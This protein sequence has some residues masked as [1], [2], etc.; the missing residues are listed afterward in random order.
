[1]APSS[2]AWATGSSPHFPSH[3][4]RRRPPWPLRRRSSPADWAPLEFRVRMAI[5]T[6]EVERRGGDLFGPPMNRGSRLLNAGP[7]RPDRSF[8]RRSEAITRD[9]GAQ[10]KSLGEH[11]F[12]GLG[13]PQAV[14]QLL[15]GRASEQLSTAEQRR[16]YRS[17]S[18][19]ASATPFVDTNFGSGS[20]G[21]HLQPSTG[22]INPRSAERWRSRS[23][24]PSSPTIRH[25]SAGSNPRHGLWHLSSIPIS[26]RFTTTGGTPTAPT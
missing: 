25:S 24:S 20:G 11:R 21:V 15:V 10:V 4:W 22:A 6:G 19:A 26:S 1:M 2:R 18:I 13:T 5:D 7:R 14:H 12:K 8:G 9:A 17:N 16:E 3:R 23:L